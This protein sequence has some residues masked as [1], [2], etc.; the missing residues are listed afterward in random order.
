MGAHVVQ[1]PVDL[2]ALRRVA[3]GL[4]ADVGRVVGV[5]GVHAAPG[6]RQHQDQRHDAQAGDDAL[7]GRLRRPSAAVLREH[8]QHAPQKQLAEEDEADA[9][10]QDARQLRAHFEAP[11][12]DVAAPRDD[13]VERPE[14]RP[15]ERHDERDDPDDHE[16]APGEGGAP[17]RQAD[18]D[19]DGHEDRDDGQPGWRVV[20]VVEVAGDQ[21]REHLP[22]AVA[23][24]QPGALQHLVARR[25]V[26]L[27]EQGDDHPGRRQ[28]G[29]RP[30]RHG[31]AYPLP[32]VR[33]GDEGPH[34]ERHEGEVPGLVVQR[35]RQH[36]EE[37]GPE[38]AAQRRQRPVG[39][40]PRQRERPRGPE[41][42]PHPEAHPHVGLGL[43][44]DAGGRGE[45]R[46][47]RGRRC[48][49]PAAQPEEPSA[50]VD[51]DR[52]EGQEQIERPA[53][54]RVGVHHR[55][56][57]PRDHGRQALVVEELGGAE[58]EIREPARQR[59]VALADAGGGG[60]DHLL[61]QG[62]VVE[63]GHGAQLGPEL[64][65]APGQR[66]GDQEPGAEP[67]GRSAVRGGCGRLRRGRGG[68]G[69]LLLDHGHG[70]P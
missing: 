1:Q 69:R 68:S 23:V 9:G 54:H 37:D 22:R 36:D 65:Q 44:P 16:G 38:G 32:Q 6:G 18:A 70:A 41:L 63:V 4:E 19:P 5:V 59:E 55:A 64:P 51:G 26:G 66:Q 21:P 56:D 39:E 34:D 62:A 11:D 13:V 58:P 53:E 20:V 14:R 57:E 50:P 40:A 25:P 7:P 29:R 17:A 33:G 8:R 31:A 27:L 28:R 48:G 24:L 45:E 2:G 15:P 43:V 10:Q 35:D 67:R 3:L 61:V 49:G 30:E 60:P 52:P 12:E 46:R 42:G 47:D